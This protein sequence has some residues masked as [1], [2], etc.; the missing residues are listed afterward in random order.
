MVDV[1]LGGLS[2]YTPVVL[3]ETAQCGLDLQYYVTFNNDNDEL[4]FLLPK[5]K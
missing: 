5:G 2:G 3:F 4:L 1:K